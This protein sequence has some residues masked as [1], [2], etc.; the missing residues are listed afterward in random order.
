MSQHPGTRVA[1][2]LPTSHQ[3]HPLALTKPVRGYRAN[4]EQHRTGR[5]PHLGVRA[6]SVTR[7]F[8]DPLLPAGP[9]ALVF[10]IPAECLQTLGGKKKKEDC[11]NPVRRLGFSLPF[12]MRQHKEKDFSSSEKA[13]GTVWP[14]FPYLPLGT[15]N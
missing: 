6:S 13:Q 3:Q 14:H 10:H 2:P 9:Q 12:W 4:W 1:P 15:G 11:H 7:G 5:L 8:S